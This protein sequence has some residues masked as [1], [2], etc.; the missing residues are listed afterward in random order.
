MPITRVATALLQG[1]FEW[2]LEVSLA[3]PGLGIDLDEAVGRA[4]LKAGST[5]FGD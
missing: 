5:W 4:H 1:N 3:E 2:L